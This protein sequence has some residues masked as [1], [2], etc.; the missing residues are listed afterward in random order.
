MSCVGWFGIS[1]AK[2]VKPYLQT[3]VILKYKDFWRFFGVWFSMC[4]NMHLPA[5]YYQMIIWFE[6]ILNQFRKIVFQPT[7]LELCKCMFLIC[8]FNK[9]ETN[10]ANNSISVL[11]ERTRCSLLWVKNQPKRTKELWLPKVLTTCG[12]PKFQTLNWGAWQENL[13]FR[14]IEQFSK[15]IKWIFFANRN[16][17]DHDPSVFR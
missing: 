3:Y 1:V 12:W 5:Y 4:E 9:S 8:I 7:I 11:S 14:G 6:E 13:A 2:C 15:Y 17:E 16:W 10:R